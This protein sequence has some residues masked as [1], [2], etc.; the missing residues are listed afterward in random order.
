MEIRDLPEVLAIEK[1]SF[2]NPWRDSTF[3]GEI[4]N[5]PISFPFVAVHKT[6]LRVIGYIVYWKIE[7]EIQINNI[8]VHPDFRGQ[9]I[10]ES[11]LRDVLD[12]ARADG[13]LFVLLEVRPSNAA[14]RSLYI[15]LGFK[16]LAIRPR[17]YSNPDEDAIVMGLYL[18]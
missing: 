2:P 7:D 4:Q 3:L 17:Y 14:A 1:V 12:G 13:A 15:K 5:E 16:F 9:G 18:R 6:Q 11:I 10:G 8:A